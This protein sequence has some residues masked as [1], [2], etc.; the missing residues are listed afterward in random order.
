MTTKTT[1]R[2]RLL[3]YRAAVAF[4]ASLL[5]AVVGVG[6]TPN[7][8]SIDGRVQNIVTGRYLNNARVTVKQ[9]DIIALTDDSGSYRL[10]RVPSGLAIIEVYYT[11]LDPQ[12]ISVTVPVGGNVTQNFGLTNAALFG[13]KDSTVKLD[14]FTVAAT[15]ETDSA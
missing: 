12:Q 8:G 7:T 3:V 10:T 4:L 14:P 9:T 15:K 2:Q 11:G 5:L 13:A 6:Q 1:H